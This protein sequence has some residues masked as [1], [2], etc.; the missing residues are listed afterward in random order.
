[1]K[2]KYDW[3]A[4]FKTKRFLFTSHFYMRRNWAISDIVNRKKAKMIRW[5]Q[6]WPGYLTHKCRPPLE[7]WFFK[8]FGR[9]GGGRWSSTNIFVPK[10]AFFAV[11]GR[12]PHPPRG[13]WKGPSASTNPRQPKTLMSSK[14]TWFANPPNLLPAVYVSVLNP[15]MLPLSLLFNHF[16]DDRIRSRYF[17]RV[18]CSPTETRSGSLFLPSQGP[19][20]RLE[21]CLPS[22]S[23]V[24]SNDASF[25]SFGFCG[26]IWCCIGCMPVFLSHTVFHFRTTSMILLFF[27]I[28]ISFIFLQEDFLP[29]IV[30]RTAPRAL[31]YQLYTSSNYFYFTIYDYP[32][33]SL[34]FKSSHISLFLCKLCISVR[35]RL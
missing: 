16:D 35:T 21:R 4:S 34:F 29:C 27:F 20:R 11:G 32:H 17:L 6:S 2:S 31:F 30:L 7:E 24:L 5:L 8:G 23:A 10:A 1:M 13:P 14:T 26:D 12:T 22:V 25:A 28:Q 18:R 15:R 9:E 33:V 3:S 19:C